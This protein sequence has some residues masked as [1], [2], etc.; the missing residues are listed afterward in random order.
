[1]ARSC[2]ENDNICEDINFQSTINNQQS[3]INNQG[4]DAFLLA[5]TSG[6]PSKGGEVPTVFI[7]MEMNNFLSQWKWINLCHGLW[8]KSA[9]EKIAQVVLPVP[10]DDGRTYAYTDK[11]I[12]ILGRLD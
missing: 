10:N 2:I 5:G 8:K 3:I 4:P 6:Q 11:D 9:I 7:S 12:P 1:M